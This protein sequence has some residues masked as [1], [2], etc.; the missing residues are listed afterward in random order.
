MEEI[1]DPEIP[2]KEESLKEPLSIC[3]SYFDIEMTMRTIVKRQS[4]EVQKVF[5]SLTPQQLENLIAFNVKAWESKIGGELSSAFDRIIREQRS[6]Q[7]LPVA[8]AFLRLTR[9]ARQKG[10]SVRFCATHYAR[11]AYSMG[12]AIGGD[13]R[14]RR[15]A[16]WSNDFRASKSAI[17]DGVNQAIAYMEQ[18]C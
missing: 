18:Y 6:G 14:Q 13:T 15:Y 17:V 8:C 7:Q 1:P 5:E 11:W 3:N 12:F 2:S 10:I 4:P 16:D 9:V